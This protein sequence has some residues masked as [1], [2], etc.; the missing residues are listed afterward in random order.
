MTTIAPLTPEHFE[1]VARWL[2]NPEINRWLS[3]D[4]R[5]RETTAS[6]IAIAA[7]NRK[8]RFYLVSHDATPCGLVALSEIDSADKTAMAWYLLGR[9]E[10]G[11][12]GVT[13]AA[14]SELV[15]RAFKELELNSVYA[16]A[17][18]SNTASLQLLAK[19]GFKRAGRIRRSSCCDGRALD[20][21]YFDI[22]PEDA[23]L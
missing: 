3:G 17:M 8:N 2:S 11:R 5:D 18:E 6:T 7:R 23:A 1:T 20:R 21:I 16:W 15:K 12:K 4:W 19:V 13:S 22:I 14:V 10:F 9:L